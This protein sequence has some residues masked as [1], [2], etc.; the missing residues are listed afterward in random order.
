[1]SEH[2]HVMPDQDIV[3]HQTSEDCVC[4]PQTEI[5]L[6]WD[7][8]TAGYIHVHSSLDGRELAER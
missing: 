6:A 2:R 5:L 4:G 7:G 8:S 3:E 1:M